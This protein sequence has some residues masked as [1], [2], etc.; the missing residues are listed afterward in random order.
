MHASTELHR[1]ERVRR[2]LVLRSRSGISVRRDA[3]ARY[4]GGTGR[5][6]RLR[7]APPADDLKIA[8]THLDRNDG[9]KLGRGGPLLEPVFKV[10]GRIL[11]VNR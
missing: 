6:R 3:A 1:G 11:S 8:P 10:H 5:C 7:A 2:T 9:E 4:C